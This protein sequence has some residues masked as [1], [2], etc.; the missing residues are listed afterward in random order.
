LFLEFYNFHQKFIK[1]YSRI[2]WP[3]HQLIRLDILFK[4]TPQ[5]QKAFETLKQALA[6]APILIHYN[7]E[8]LMRVEIDISDRV[9]AA[10]L[11]QLYNNKE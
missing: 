7:P 1:V 10:V 4:W 6:T 3:L 11:S 9:V 5:C 2:A 8:L